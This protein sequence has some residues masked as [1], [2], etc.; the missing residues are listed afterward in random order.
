MLGRPGATLSL[1]AAVCLALLAT[2][3]GGG[4][5]GQLRITKMS[6]CVAG[7]PSPVSARTLIRKFAARGIAMRRDHPKLC[8][9]PHIVA[10]VWN[11]DLHISAAQERAAKM[12]H[13]AITCELYDSARTEEL[14][15][16]TFAHGRTAAVFTLKNVSCT[17]YPS[18][19]IYL[20][21]PDH[22]REQ[23]RAVQRVMRS[24]SR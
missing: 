14:E 18:S 11:S 15:R 9:D 10:S 16:L 13:G 23:D 5:A 4:G 6:P 7:T 12:R 22:H 20:G 24:L 19:Q 3:C 8:P 21:S 1:A 17:V 2:G